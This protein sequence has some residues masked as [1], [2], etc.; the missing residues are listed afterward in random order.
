MRSILFKHIGFC[1]FL[2]ISIVFALLF[3]ATGS[4]SDKHKNEVVYRMIGNDTV[5]V[6]DA[7][8]I[9]EC[10]EMN[11]SEWISDFKMVRF[12]NSDTAFFKAW[13]VYI[14][15]HYIG[16]LQDAMSP[17]KLFDHDGRFVCDI[18]RIGEGPGEYTTLYSA[19]MDEK[20]N[21]ICLAPFTGKNL[22]KYDF[23]GNFIGAVHVGKMQKPQIRIESD[24]SISLIHLCLKGIT[25]FQYARIDTNN[26]LM[27]TLP[28]KN[29][30]IE[31]RDKEGAFVGYNHEVW[32]YNNHVDFSY[33]T[34]AS[35]TLYRID[36]R[37]GQISPRFV[38]TNHQGYGCIH[39]ELPSCFM[40]TLFSLEREVEE[41]K[42]TMIVVDKESRLAYYVKITNDKVGGIPCVALPYASNGWYHE[43]YEPSDLVEKIDEYLNKEHG[44]DKD[45]RYLQ[46]LR[47]SIDEEDN[48]VM[49]IGR[50]LN[51]E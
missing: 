46:V 50:L 47:N 29:R 16:I 5:F 38:M 28:N 45:K 41:P 25:D 6:C 15:D 32:F 48:N 31:P 3:V 35:D 18:G 39:N 42:F 43:M 24:G 19:A 17:F 49:F 12:E 26:E 21:T 2:K 30:A 22:F 40:V 11:L 10:K 14:T 20:T 37:N 1:Y 4:C 51:K 36:T 7:S 13:K 44:S 27:R 34:T 9:S 23:Q 33:M 8:N